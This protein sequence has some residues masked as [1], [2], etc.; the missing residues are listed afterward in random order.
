FLLVRGLPC[1]STCPGCSC[2]AKEKRR[3]VPTED[4]ISRSPAV[5]TVALMPG[6]VEVR[7]ALISFASAARLVAVRVTPLSVRLPLLLLKLGAY[8]VAVVRADAVI[9]ASAFSSEAVWAAEIGR[10]HV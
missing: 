10:A 6:R 3:S 2:P 4:T 5:L 7:S 8:R 9:P 1:R